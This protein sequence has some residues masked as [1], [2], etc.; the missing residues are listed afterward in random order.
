MLEQIP[1]L[2]DNVVGFEAKGEITA[3]DYQQHLVPGDRART[4]STRQDPSP[5]RSRR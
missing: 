1:N 3:D 5:L 2:P 4:R